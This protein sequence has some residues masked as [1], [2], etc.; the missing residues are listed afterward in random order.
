[1]EIFLRKKVIEDVNINNDGLAVYVALRKLMNK[2]EKEYFVSYNMI[3]YSLYGNTDYGRRFLDHIKYGLQ[4]LID[5]ELIKVVS[6]IGKTEFICDLSK[7]FFSTDN[8]AETKDYFI[9]IYTDEVHKIMQSNKDKFNLLKCFIHTV[10][11]MDYKAKVY[12]DI[13]YQNVEVGYMTQDYLGSLCGMVQVDYYKYS[14]ELENIGVL[15]VKRNEDF[16]LDGDIPKR[17]INCYGRPSDKELI[18]KYADKYAEMK[19]SVKFKS[20]RNVNLK[21]TNHKKSLAMKYNA[22]VGGKRYSDAETKEIYEYCLAAN[23]NYEKQLDE[24]QGNS[25]SKYEEELKEKL[26][27]KLRDISVFDGLMKE[28]EDKVFFTQEEKVPHDEVWGK[29]KPFSPFGYSDEE[30]DDI[31]NMKNN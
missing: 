7:L 16:Y 18:D 30:L 1:M 23:K 13:A 8:V 9:K 15:Y 26:E 6:T 22:I 12:I 29:D 3:A 2:D 31:F 5:M 24:L 17:L 19:D 27:N 25:L 4:N 14:V 21:K 10:G 11:S 20:G 28:K